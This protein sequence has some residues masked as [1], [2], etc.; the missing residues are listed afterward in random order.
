MSTDFV[1]DILNLV[2]EIFSDVQDSGSAF[3][4]VKATTPVGFSFPPCNIGKTKDGE[5]LFK[6]AVAGYSEEDIDI[7]FTENIMKLTF[8]AKDNSGD[9]V[10]IFHKGIKSGETSVKIAIPTKC[11]VKNTKASLKDGILKVI[12]PLFPKEERSESKVK[13]ET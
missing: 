6:F 5:L 10:K 4:D 7:S 2:S 3:S 9:F 11:N 8:K 13:I 1:V 12:I